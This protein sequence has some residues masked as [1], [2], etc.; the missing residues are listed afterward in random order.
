MNN[1]TQKQYEEQEWK[2][3][4]I[5][6]YDK[7]KLPKWDRQQGY[8]DLLADVIASPELI[9]DRINWLLNGTYGYGEMKIA[10]Q[11]IQLNKNPNSVLF[12]LIAHWE[13]YTSAYYARKVYKNLTKEQQNNLNKL[14]SEEVQ[15][16]KDCQ[17]EVAE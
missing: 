5:S 8:K 1:L 6:Y 7:E 2:R 15:Y 12:D 14:V 4:N 17:R 11:A 10:E 16:W 13:W 9:S 3:A